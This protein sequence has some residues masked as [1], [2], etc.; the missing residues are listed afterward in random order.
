MMK[1][2]AITIID[3]MF[4][5]V[6]SVSAENLATVKLFACLSPYLLRSLYFKLCNTAATRRRPRQLHFAWSSYWKMYTI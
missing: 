4:I 2:M 5:F 6:C 1:M 3:I